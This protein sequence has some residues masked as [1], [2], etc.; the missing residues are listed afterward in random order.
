[1]VVPPEV[2][3]RPDVTIRTLEVLGYLTGTTVTLFRGLRETPDIAVDTCSGY[4]LARKAN[5]PPDWKS[6]VVQN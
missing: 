1:M 5:L 3:K 4:N 6:Y 2:L